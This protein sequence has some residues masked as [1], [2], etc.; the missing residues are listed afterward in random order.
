MT[1]NHAHMK[2]VYSTIVIIVGFLLVRYSNWIV[3]NF[4]YMDWA[5][6]YL[7]TYGGSRLFWK[8]IGIL[9]IVGS[10]LVISGIMQTMLFS[11]FSRLGTG[12]I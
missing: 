2:Y 9:F 12:G 1:I 10:L 4:G 6:H 8:L 11:F 7:G 5:E 3:S